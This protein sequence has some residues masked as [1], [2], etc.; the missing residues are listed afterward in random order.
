MWCDFE[1]SSCGWTNDTTSDFFWTRAQKATDTLGTGPTTGMNAP[2]EPK[3]HPTNSVADHTTGTDRG[4]YL[5]IETSS[6]QKPGQKARIVSPKYAPSS[7]VCLKFHY[8]M[9]GASIG[10]LNVLLASTKQLLWTKRYA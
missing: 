8:H 10:T 1:T 5:Y 2:L 6:P 4:Y 3:R 7:S 9:Y